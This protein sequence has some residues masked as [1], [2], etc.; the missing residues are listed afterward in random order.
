[1]RKR[2]L[3]TMVSLFLLS[4]FLM[5]GCGGGGGGGGTNPPSG[6]N[7]PQGNIY[8]V[9]TD[10]GD[11]EQC[12]GL[13]NAPYPGSGTNQ[14]CAW[15]HPFW[16]LRIV[17]GRPEWRLSPG[18]TLIIA[19]GSYRMGYGAPNTSWC[20]QESA[21]ECLLP[22]LPNNLRILG[23]GW[24]QGCQNP[25]ELW[26]TERAYYIFEISG[27]SGVTLACLELT[28]H[29][30]CADW[31]ANS[32]VRCNSDNPP[33][34][35]WGYRGILMRDASNISLRDLN[36]HGFAVEGIEAGRVQN[37]SLERVRIAGNGWSGWNGDLCGAPGARYDENGKCLETSSN[38][39]DIV[40]RNVII[41]W[42]GCVESYP[43]KQ[44][45]HCWAQS[46]GGYGD[47]LGTA[48]TGG[49]WIIE[50]ST[51]RYNTSDGLDLLYAVVSTQSFIKLNRVQ[52]YGNAGNQ[53]KVGGP[54]VI[55]NTLAIGN[56]NY[57]TGKPFAQEMGD[58]SSGDAC[59]A[60]GATI[61]VN[62]KPNDR[63]AIINST[64]LSEGWAQVE[65]YCGTYSFQEAQ[66]CTGSEILYLI[67]NIFLGFRN[68]TV[69]DREDWPD[70][71]GDN[72]PEHRTRRESIDYNLIYNTQVEVPIG[73]NNILSDPQLVKE[74][75]INDIDAHLKSG[76]P[77][78]DRGAPV[79]REFG[80]GSVPNHDIV[81]TQ[82][83]KGQGVDLGAYEF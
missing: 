68:A 83:P 82:R 49:N 61:S 8:Y 28:D 48:A 56:C 16:A 38:Q 66:P 44:P 65:A 21:Y 13:A 45:D 62:M 53:I 14:Q 70:L 50:D 1:M 63:S 36:I 78:I 18:D 9:R 26:A 69:T 6:E 42:N 47:G 12:T 54:T 32:E 29:L 80:L 67:N 79:G 22:P 73:D 64:I 5:A 20:A 11:A 4:L 71:I 58:V 59:R 17:D 33:F 37:I 27:V 35:D 74:S 60:G 77:A 57:F 43:S 75:D 46:A 55:T 30:G 2:G 76:S 19:P 81:N 3:F 52:A 31:H 72:D 40:F 39:G 15:S 24:D 34:G 7:P 51:F 23:E 10:G 25:P 41:E